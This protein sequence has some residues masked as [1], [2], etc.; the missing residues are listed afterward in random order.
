MAT[1]PKATIKDLYH[2]PEDGKAEVINGELISRA[3]TGFLPRPRSGHPLPEP[4]RI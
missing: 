1:R 4:A 2:S 3:P